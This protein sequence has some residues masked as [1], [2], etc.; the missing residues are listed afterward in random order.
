MAAHLR[1]SR[2][3][4]TVLST[5]MSTDAARLYAG[6]RRALRVVVKP[7]APLPASTPYPG[8]Y[9]VV[10]SVVEGLR[11]VGADFNFNPASV[12]ESGRVI[13]APANEALRQAAD[14]KRRGAIAALI[15][16]P[17]N[18]FLPH[19]CDNILL[20]PEIDVLI[21]ASEWVRELYALIAPAISHKVRVCQAGVDTDYWKPDER[22]R[23]R[24]AVVYWKDGPDTLSEE[25]ERVLKATGLATVRVQYGAYDVSTYKELLSDAPLAVFLSTF[26]TQGLALAEAWAM[27]VPTLVWNPQAPTEWRGQAFVAGSSCPLLT[28]M[29]G[30]TWK[31]LGELE[32][33][34]RDV[35]ANPTQFDPRAWVLA[36]MTDAI[37]ASAL[38]R[39]VEETAGET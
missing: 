37:C 22:T 19:E 38:Y 39:I 1:V 6:V 25:A 17:T 9:A 3:F 18:A 35:L 34:A 30:R 20:T 10:R 26:E 8:H 29:T 33:A 31:M 5:P 7:R 4:L 23:S 14:L 32:T 15:A 24:R 16:G 12:A 13:Y 11:A 2:P 36:N 28:P 21:V 27:D